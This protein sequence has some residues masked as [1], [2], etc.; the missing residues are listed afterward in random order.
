MADGEVGTRIVLARGGSIRGQAV[1]G[2]GAPVPD[3][4]ISASH[5]SGDTYPEGANRMLSFGQ[6]SG[7]RVLTDAEGKFVLTALAGTDRFVVRAE[8]PFGAADIKR[9]VSPGD[10]VTLT[11]PQLSALRGTVEDEDGRPVSSF[12]LQVVHVATGH[13]RNAQLAAQAGRWSLDGVPSGAL[14]LT[15]TG[16]DGSQADQE[17]NAPSGQTADGVR[18][19]LRRSANASALRDLA[20][21]LQ[22][23]GGP[24]A[25]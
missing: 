13:G 11:L 9:G 20:A 5:E 3:V 12:S 15:A 2:T 17:M 24:A 7:R 6:S 21:A 19:V 16:A 1:D 14:R 23:A 4:W 18:F 25:Q 10:V 22:A 8:Q